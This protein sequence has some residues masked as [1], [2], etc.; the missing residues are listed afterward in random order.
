[1]PLSQYQKGAIKTKYDGLHGASSF[2]TKKVR[3]KH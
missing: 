3:L 1:L 2:N